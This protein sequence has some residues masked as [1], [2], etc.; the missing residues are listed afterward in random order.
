MS[1][2]RKGKVVANLV[3]TTNDHNLRCNK[4]FTKLFESY[5]SILH[6]LFKDKII[7]LENP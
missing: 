5:S 1:I 2:S 7:T 6:K 4:K 3:A